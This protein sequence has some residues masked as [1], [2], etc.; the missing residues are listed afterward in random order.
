MR[1]KVIYILVL[2]WCMINMCKAQP[3]SV[4]H[5]PSWPFLCERYAYSSE[6]E[7]RITKT[8][9]GG[10]L[11]I[12]VESATP[13]DTQIAG[14]AYVFLKNNTLIT[15]TDKNKHSIE[16]SKVVSMY[17]FNPAEMKQLQQSD[18]DYIHFNLKGKASSFS[19]QLGNFTAVNK[20]AYFGKDTPENPNYFDT[21]LAI[22]ALY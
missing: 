9:K 7:V 1:Q 12:A 20:R 4:A 5:T 19:S 21:A 6:V 13:I 18:I 11:R 8:P 22:K 10:Y 14:T 15:C 2:N 3:A 16:G 17:E